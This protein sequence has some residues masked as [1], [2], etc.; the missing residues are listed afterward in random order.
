[1]IQASAEWSIVPSRDYNEDACCSQCIYCRLQRLRIAVLDFRA[2]LGII[3]Y[4]GTT[5]RIPIF[6]RVSVQRER[7]QHELH[8]V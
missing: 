8:T 6:K 2:A 5:T 4:I 1:M 3:Q 7:R